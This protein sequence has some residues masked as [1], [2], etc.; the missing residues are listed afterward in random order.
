MVVGAIRTLGLSAAIVFSMVAMRPCHAQAIDSVF[1]EI[2]HVQESGISGEPP[3]I[4][5]RVYVDLAPGYELQMVYGDEH[6]Q[7]RINTSTWFVNDTMNGVQYAHLLD[8]DRLNTAPLALD[9]WLTIGAASDAHWGVPRSLD[10]DGSVLEC[11]PYPRPQVLNGRSAFTRSV[12][13]N[14]TDGLVAHPKVQEVTNF[15]FQSGYLGKVRGSFLETTNGA[16]AV[17]GGTKG[18]TDLN[19]VLLGQFTTTGELSY[20]LNLQVETPDHQPVKYVAIDPRP[21]E[22]MYE[23]L[24]HGMYRISSPSGK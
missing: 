14:I 19:L 12:P 11:P 1:V 10:V 5:Y 23:G 17:L 9:T 22:V 16:W 20:R 3:L 15:Q 4:T 2:Y 8:A 7:L 24:D 21:G 13:L 6:H 18:I